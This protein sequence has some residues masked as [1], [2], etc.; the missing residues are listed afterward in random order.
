M[1]EIKGKP[2][3]KDVPIIMLTSRDSLI[4]KV[5]SRVSGTE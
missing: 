1:D 3:M 2:G 4:D 5:R